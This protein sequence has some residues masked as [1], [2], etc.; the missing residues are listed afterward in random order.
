M[1]KRVS[2]KLNIQSANT[3]NRCIWM[4]AGVISFKLC[5]LNYD[6]EHCDFDEVMRSQVRSKGVSSRVKRHKPKTVVPS[7]RLPMSSSDSKKSLFFTFSVGEVKEGL[8]LHPTHLWVRRAEGQR[9]RLGIDKLLAYVLPPPVKVELY[10]LDKDVIQNQAFGKIHTQV[11]TVFLTV[12]ISGRLVQT[13]SRLAQCPELVQQDP[14]GEGWLAMMDWFEDHSKLEKFHTGL[15]GK[16]F[17]EEEAQHLKFLLKHR[18][19]E[20]DYI[21]E[22]LPDGGVNI[23]YLH[24]VLPSQVC[25]GLAG[26]LIVTGHQAW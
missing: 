26:E 13:N 23:K 19:I 15:A 7:E 3:Q 6:C 9:W 10:D 5:P 4:T 11:G 14:H 20:A 24:Q 22:T 1:K 8:Y 17:L 2:K 16:R 21:G 18:G 12:P 25:L